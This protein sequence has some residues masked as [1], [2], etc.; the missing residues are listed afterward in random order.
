MKTTLKAKPP[1]PLKLRAATAADLMT[2]EPVSVPADMPLAEA[3]DLLVRRGLS[4][5]PV[6]CAAGRPVGVI[7]RTDLVTRDCDTRDRAR[8][9]EYYVRPDLTVDIPERPVG[10]VGPT[11]VRAFMTPVVFAVRPEASARGV[12]NEMLRLKVHRL[13]VVDEAGVLAG[14]VSMTDVLRHLTD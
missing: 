5:A 3:V 11:A 8:V 13:F 1:R 2:E 4:A 9:H 10:A 14:V 12:V 6:V 7:S